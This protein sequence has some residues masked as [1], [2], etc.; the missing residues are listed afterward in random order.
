MCIPKHRGEER[1]GEE[2]RG[3]KK[4]RTGEKK[5]CKCLILGKAPAEMVRS[6]VSFMTEMRVMVNLQVKA[7]ED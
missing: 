4:Q 6:A 5:N 1:R 3:D 7:K 2:I